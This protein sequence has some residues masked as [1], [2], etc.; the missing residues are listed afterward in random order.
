[1]RVRFKCAKLQE[2]EVIEA[3]LGWREG[4]VEGGQGGLYLNLIPREHRNLQKGQSKLCVLP[5]SN[6]F[7]ATVILNTCGLYMHDSTIFDR[8]QEIDSA[9]DLK[10]CQRIGMLPLAQWVLHGGR[11]AA[12][13][14]RPFHCVFLTVALR[15]GAEGGL[16]TLLCLYCC[17]VYLPLPEADT[18]DAENEFL[19]IA[20]HFV[21]IKLVYYVPT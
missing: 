14:E 2:A 3:K 1:M 9:L 12:A 10:A 15:T 7:S 13:L 5:R 19:P 21:I 4:G 16:S 8:F 6:N 18:L 17:S 20:F 11:T